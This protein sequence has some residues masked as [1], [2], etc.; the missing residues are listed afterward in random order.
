[1]KLTAPQR[2]VLEYLALN[3][4]ETISGNPP[5]NPP[6]WDRW[7]AGR[8]PRLAFPTFNTLHMRE[9]VRAIAHHPSADGM[10]ERYK[11]Q[12]SDKGIMALLNS[13]VSLAVVGKE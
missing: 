8:T 3:P 10:P 2:R 11:Y 4:D 7:Y 5:F 12:I 6:W 1:M 13:S 9:M